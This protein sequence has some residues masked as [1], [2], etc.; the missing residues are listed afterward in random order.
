[1]KRSIVIFREDNRDIFEYP[2]MHSSI[3]S[4]DDGTATVCGLTYYKIA[5]SLDAA[6]DLFRDESGKFTFPEKP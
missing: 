2:G 5:P 4:W 6:L 3:C 1:M